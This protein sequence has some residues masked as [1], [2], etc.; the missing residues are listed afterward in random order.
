MWF[1]PDP[2]ELPDASGIHPELSSARA[3]EAL[4]DA[5]RRT[6]IVPL[7]ALRRGGPSLFGKLENRQETGSFKARGALWNVMALSD[8]ERARGVV[9]SSSG[10]HGRALAWAA[11][12]KGVRATIVMA[13]NAYPNKIEACRAEGAEVVLAEDRFGADV[14]AAERAEAGAVW[15]HPYD[16]P[17]TV[18]GA[19]TVGVEIAEHFGGDPPDAVVFCVGGGGL[20]SGSAL[21]LRRAYGPRVALFGAEPVGAATMSAGLAAGASVP[22]EAITSGVQGLTP[23]FAGGLNVELCGA[24]LDGVI[25]L[26]DEAILAAQAR[27][28]RPAGAWAGE[29]VEPAGGAAYAAAGSDVF[30]DRV[31]ETIGARG[32]AP[33]GRPLRVV[34]TVSGG[35]PDPA[36]LDALRAEPATGG[37]Q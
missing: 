25:T 5:V 7:P 24:L 2:S 30:A 16:R 35:N 14:I 6:P 13:K 22:L 18:E 36:Q 34:V 1:R 32:F 4:G 9:A 31:L 15:V 17:G 19:G 27:L 8:E 29:V 28:V 11:G 20:A 37:A 3:R 23:P 10:N 33:A 12:L 26:P 21:A